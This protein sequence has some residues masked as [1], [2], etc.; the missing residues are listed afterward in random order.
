MSIIDPKKGY[1]TTHYHIIVLTL[2]TGEEIRALAPATRETLAEFKDLRVKRVAV[3]PIQK[4]PDG[5]SLEYVEGDPVDTSPKKEHGAHVWG[6]S[7]HGSWYDDPKNNHPVCPI[8]G[9]EPTEDYG[10]IP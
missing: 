10:V 4:L 7:L 6:C 5:Y 9:N 2:T 1:S 3:G 8:C